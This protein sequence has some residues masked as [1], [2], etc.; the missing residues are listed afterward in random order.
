MNT[1]RLMI[2]IKT[3]NYIESIMLN[4]NLFREHKGN[5]PE[6]VR[7]SQ[8]A[9]YA[10][11]DLVD[12]VI[13]LDKKWISA[14]Y[15]TEQT[16]KR[17]NLLKKEIG[18]KMKHGMN[19][20]GPIADKNKLD[21]EI[22]SDESNKIY[23]D[24]VH[25]L[26]TMG[27]IVHA[28]VP[29][30]NDETNNIIVRTHGSPRIYDFKPKSHYEIM[31][32]LDIIDIT[33]GTKISG[34][35]G[36]FLKDYGVLLNQALINYS[37]A[38]LRKKNYIL[39]QPPYFMFKHIMSETVQLSDY[40]DNL[41][42]INDKESSEK[43][44][45]ATS[46]QPI[47]AYHRGE[48]IKEH[49][50]PIKY[51][52]LSACFRK[53]AGASGKD[54]QGIFRV[55]QFE[56]V[57]QFCLCL[58]EKSW[59]LFEEMIQIAEEFYQSLGLHYRISNIVSGALNNA[60]AKKYDL[61][62]WFPESQLFRELVSCSNCTDYQSNR[63]NIR[64]KRNTSNRSKEYVHCLNSTLCATER[65]LCCLVETYQTSAGINIPLALQSY[66]GTDFIQYKK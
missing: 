24:I 58:P 51:A 26:S 54:V 4:I 7:E 3:N 45:I 50:L 59:D 22:K 6:L 32:K 64:L 35:R 18:I 31:Q 19:C 47:S 30:S 23:D 1:S 52:G 60:A 34:H 5:D 49:D 53:E 17:L 56:K 14:C 38:F 29:I 42:Q 36:Y 39:L 25:K 37:L 62:A 21:D 8:R 63:L 44:L 9:R 10:S 28:S 12:E 2:I 13:D 61:E 43:Y 41:Y 15:H 57:E 65:T 48:N 40:D 20:D 16:R 55:H 46:E 33:R 11:V 27:N 66:I